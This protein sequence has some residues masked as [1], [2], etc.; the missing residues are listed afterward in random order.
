WVGAINPRAL[1]L[2]GQVG[3]GWNIPFASPETFRDKLAV[4]KSN[5][6]DPDRLAIGVNLGLVVAG[7]AEI[8]DALAQRFGELATFARPGILAGST[9]EI[10]ERVGRYV[11]VGADWIVLALRAPF[12]LEMLESFAAEVVP[13]FT[14]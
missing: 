1:A 8:D 4:V 9:A 11:E 2:A 3:D 14:S 5:A 10:A 7:P 12:D 6:P 13:Q